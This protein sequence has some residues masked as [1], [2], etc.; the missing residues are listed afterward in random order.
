MLITKAAEPVN[1][2]AVQ[3]P[4]PTIARTSTAKE[5]R[6][7]G[8][9]PGTRLMGVAM[10]EGTQLIYYAVK[11]LRRMRPAFQL[12]RATYDVIYELIARFEPD[13]LAYETSYY[14]QQQGSLLLRAHEREIQRCAAAAK[15]RTVAY[16]PLYVRQRLCADAYSTKHMVAAALVEQFPELAGYR[17][18]QTPRG[19]RYWLNMFDALAVAVVA[20]REFKYDPNAGAAEIAPAA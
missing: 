13:V 16:S 14:V 9:D 17:T 19:E 6:V 1:K 11:E 12:K 3:L 20:A 7:L 2:L 4:G 15:V 18:N 10:L 8:I 5:P